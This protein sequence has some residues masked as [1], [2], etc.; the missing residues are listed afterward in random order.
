[1]ILDNAPARAYPLRPPRSGPG[2]ALCR[3][4]NDKGVGL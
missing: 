4:C 2:L 1:M 3:V